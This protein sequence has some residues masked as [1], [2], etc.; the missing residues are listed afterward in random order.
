MVTINPKRREYDSLINKFELELYELREKH[1][2]SDFDFS[3]ICSKFL[4]GYSQDNIKKKVW[5]RVL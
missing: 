5:K 1:N 3:V 2:I 4:Y